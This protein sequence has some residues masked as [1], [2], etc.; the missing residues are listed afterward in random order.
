M[1]K[2]R[3]STSRL[4]STSLPPTPA[5]L[6]LR[7]QLPARLPR[8]RR[9]RVHQPRTQHIVRLQSLGRKLRPDAVYPLGPKPLLDDA[10]HKGRKLRLL[11]ALVVAQLDVHKVQPPERMRRLDAAVQMHAAVPARVALDRGRG[12]DNVQFVR[13]GGDGERGGGEDADDGEQGAGG[14]PALGAAAGVVVGDVA[15]EGD[16]D[17]VAGAVAVEFSPGEVGRA[18]GD[19]VVDEGVDGR[20]GGGWDG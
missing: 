7:R 6:Q 11:P 8:K 19:A 1:M 16:L 15:G 14:L 10:A 9:N 17:F 13:V 5:T 18:F 4:H 12:V 20:H 3:I 2:F